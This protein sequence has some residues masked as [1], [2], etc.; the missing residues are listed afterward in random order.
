LG[1]RAKAAG[2]RQEALRSY[3]DAFTQYEALALTNPRDA[4]VQ[5]D[6]MNAANTLGAIQLEE[7]D[8]PGAL[9]SYTRALQITE[10]LAALEGSQVTPATR[11]EVAAANRR[12]GAL[13]VRNGAREAGLE[14]LR[15]ALEIYRQL[16]ANPEIADLTRQLAP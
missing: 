8:V 1:D 3:Q 11:A 13:Q 6:V 12:V 14:K 10:G 16:G 5:R 2:N 9:S 15:K 4:A 7:D